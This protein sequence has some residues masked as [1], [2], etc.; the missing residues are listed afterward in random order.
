ML[1]SFELVY[2]ISTLAQGFFTG[3]CLCLIPKSRKVSIWGVG[4]LV[5]V[6]MGV[7]FTVTKVIWEDSRILKTFSM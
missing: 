7:G 6:K 2:L 1:Y 5:E 4:T 3:V